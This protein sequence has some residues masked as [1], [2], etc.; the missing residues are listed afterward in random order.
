MSFLT[1]LYALGLLAVAAPIVFHLIRRTPRGDIPFSSLMFLTP[2]PP[3]L[4][5]RSRLD[6]WLLLLL[7]AAALALLAAAFARPFLRQQ[8]LAD[9]GE[10]GGRRIAVLIDSSASMR[11]ADLWPRAR[12]LTQEVVASSV[13]ADRLAVIAFDASSRPI[14][15]FE[16]SA[17]LDPA[18]LRATVKSRLAALEPSWGATN[19]GRALV[20]AAAAIGDLAE[21]GKKKT[22]APGRIVLISDL[23]Q[24]SRLE[25]LG[26]LEWPRDVELEVR[27]VSAE[28]TNAGLHPLPEGESA[29]PDAADARAGVRVSNDAASRRESFE[30]S[31]IDERGADAGKP[32]PVYV[33]PGESRVVRVLRPA[34]SATYRGLRLRG[35]AHGFDNTLYL[36]TEPRREETVV[37]VGPDRPDD[38]TGLLY[39]LERV[40]PETARRSVKVRP[41][42]PTAGLTFEPGVSVPLVVLTGTTTPAN[43]E[44]L[45][46]FVD[47]GGTLL[48]VLGAGQGPETLAV[49]AGTPPFELEEK[50]PDRGA[51]LT[52]IRFDHPLFAPLSGPQFNDFTKIRFWKYR[53]LAPGSLGDARVLAKFEGGDPAIVEKSPGRGWIVILTGG[54]A[55]GDSQLARSS[56][57]FPLMSA[58]LDGPNSR[59]PGSASV[60]VNDRVPLPERE[61]GP[62]AALAVVKPDGVRVELKPESR[63]FDDTDE[64]GV[65][66]V[67][68]ARG[69]RPFAVNLDPGESKTAPLSLETLEQFGCRLASR[70]PA[71]TDPEQLRQLQGQ[72]LEARQKLWR[73]LILAVIGVLIV[74]T[75]LAGRT[76]AHR[77]KLAEAMAR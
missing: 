6:D 8:A 35:D 76:R 45:R 9:A 47:D 67:E 15:G 57:F 65:Y 69:A 68:A 73:W 42:T 29:A 12:A 43:L 62:A 10:A 77:P 33:P 44:R 26:E 25:A 17:S 3:R 18:Q 16:E 56:K 51:L 30:L 11:R 20:D 27:T 28:G 14:L 7:R 31:W 49:L 61:R 66:R 37:F 70:V 58:F 48:Y 41:V 46:K 21:G 13:P 5:R 34:G 22:A 24:G 50:A 59:R 74:E 38:P 53:R 36:A 2:T 39:Y 32:V 64:P 71:E 19:L 60:L 54:W 72:E 4:T 52:E 75:W 1:P 63:E 23:Q 55:P 40:Y